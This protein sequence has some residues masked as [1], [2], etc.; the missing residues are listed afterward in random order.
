MAKHHLT[1][2]LCLCYGFYILPLSALHKGRSK[3]ASPWSSHCKMPQESSSYRTGL[4]AFFYLSHAHQSL[5]FMRCTA[6]AETVQYG[7]CCKA[8][9][10]ATMYNW[11]ATSHILKDGATNKHKSGSSHVPMQTPK[12]LLKGITAV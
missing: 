8:S 2:G 9:R 12:I 4:H 5:P 6:S 10:L 3:L 1:L 7:L 11:C